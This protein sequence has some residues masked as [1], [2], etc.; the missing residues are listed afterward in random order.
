MPGVAASETTKT[1]GQAPQYAEFS[2]R[3]LSVNRTTGVEPTRLWK[4]GRD[5]SAIT[6][7]EKNQ[8]GTHCAIY[9]LGCWPGCLNARSNSSP[10]FFTEIPAA[11]P[12][13][14]TRKS[15]DGVHPTRRRR[16]NSRTSR[17]IRFRVTELPTFPLTVIP[18][19]HWPRSLGL[20]ITTK[21]ADGFLRPARDS[22]R[23]SGRFLRRADFGNFSLPGGNILSCLR[24]GALRR[25]VH[26]QSLPPLG[27]APLEHFTPAGCIHAGEKTVGALSAN[28]ARLIGSFHSINTP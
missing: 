7:Q 10:A 17:L 28:I 5:K 11:P 20:L 9:A 12:L 22:F 14:M 23:N 16:K 25:H 26:R 18:N 21:F 27:A 6:R 8:S 15:Q 13:A 4:Q 19:R 24:T 2:N 1:V 3:V